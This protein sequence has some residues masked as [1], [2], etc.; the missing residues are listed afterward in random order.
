MSDPLALPLPPDDMRMLVGPTDTDFFDNPTRRPIFS[1]MSLDQYETVF[2]FGCGCG[3]LARQLLQQVPRPRRYIGIDLHLGMI[4]WCRENLQT[5]STGFEFI[6]HDVHNIGLNPGK[7]KPRTLAFPAPDKSFKLVIGW[8]VFTH[9]L[10]DQVGYYLNEVAR[11]L[12]PTGIFVSTW[13]LFEK[14]Y[15]PMMQDFQNALF[16]NPTDPTNAVIFDVR[17]LQRIAKEIGLKIVQVDPPA[18]RGF[19]WLVHMVAGDSH[20]TEVEFPEDTAV[21][22]I[23]RP[24]VPEGNRT[25][26]FGPAK[27]LFMKRHAWPKLWRK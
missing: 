12:Q 6:H 18:I 24:P 5:R 21:F 16:I 19:Q 10:E 2:D 26:R 17:W 11:I 8:S 14:R 15:F 25:Y 1:D 13:F 3:R 4:K 9:L 20:R 23:N 27:N 22:G 7:Y